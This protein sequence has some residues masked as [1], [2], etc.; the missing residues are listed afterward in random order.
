MIQ[1]YVWLCQ[2]NCLPRGIA[3]EKIPA[4]DLRLGAW[5]I[6]AGMVASG[7]S[8]CPLHALAV[9]SSLFPLDLRPSPRDIERRPRLA[10]YHQALDGTV[11]RLQ[12]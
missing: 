2:D 4:H 10:I 12:P 8:G 7:R 3:A 5:L 9:E 6:E 1:T 11:V